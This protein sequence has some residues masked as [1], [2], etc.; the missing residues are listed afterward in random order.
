MAELAVDD[1]PTAFHLLSRGDRW[2]AATALI[3]RVVRIDFVPSR[4]PAG[5]DFVVCGEV[6]TVATQQGGR[7]VSDVVVLRP[8][9]RRDV[10]VTMWRIQQ[11]TARDP[12]LAAAV[13][14]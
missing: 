14:T 7:N 9:G 3:G 5:E 6:V 2:R 1:A 10:A 11:I 13:A 12:E 8:V 4:R